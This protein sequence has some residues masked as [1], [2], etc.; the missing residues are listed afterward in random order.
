MAT[1]KDI[2]E[3]VMAINPRATVISSMGSVVDSNARQMADA[4]RMEIMGYLPKDSAA[5]DI[6]TRC[7]RISEKQGWVVAYELNRNAEYVADLQKFLDEVEEHE[8]FRKAARKAARERRAAREAAGTQP[9]KTVTV[10]V[11]EAENAPFKAGDVVKHAKF[12][13]GTVE[14]CNARTTV[15]T[16]ASVGSKSFYTT[17]A[18]KFLSK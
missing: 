3:E 1:I 12:G 18:E 5:Y 10:K 17:M 16:F 14:D 2:Y 4:R 7:S 11:T 9:H 15:V 6:V 13:E 8:T